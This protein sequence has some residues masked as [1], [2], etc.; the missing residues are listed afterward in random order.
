LV[1]IPAECRSDVKD[2]SEGF[3]A[4][5]R[6]RGFVVVNAVALS[7]AFSNVTNFVS[8]D[9]ASV[10]TLPF[11]DQLTLK[12]LLAGWHGG[13]RDEDKHFEVS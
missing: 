6:G 7:V 9:G 5:S 2:A 13:A 4:C 3:E 11:A 8:Y 12:R 1:E 10:V